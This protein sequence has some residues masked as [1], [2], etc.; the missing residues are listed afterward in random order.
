[1]VA[2]LILSPVAARLPPLAVGLLGAATIT[3]VAIFDL[4]HRARIAGEV[5]PAS[6]G[7]APRRHPA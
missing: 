5:N 3:V 1:M 4:T 2:C 7:D 6:A